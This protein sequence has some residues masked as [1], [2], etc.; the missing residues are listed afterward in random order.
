[1]TER[2]L[3]CFWLT[4]SGTAGGSER[5]FLERARALVKQA[6]PHGGSL[7]SWGGAHV[8]L[9]FE[10]EAIE[11]GVALVAA[12]LADT[13]EGELPWGVALAQGEFVQEK[14]GHHEIVGSMALAEAEALARIAQP[15]DVLVAES[16]AAFASGEMLTV[17]RRSGIDR[18]KRIRAARL[19]C[20]RPWK[21]EAMAHIAQ[22]RTTALVGRED[23]SA[24][25]WM[26]GTL[27]ILRADPGLGG[28]R[29]LADLRRLVEPGPCLVVTPSGSGLEPL[30]AL[31]RAIARACAVD[32]QPFEPELEPA[33]NRLLAGS[34]V[35]IETAATLIASMLKPLAESAPPGALLLDDAAE[36]DSTTLAACARALE[37][38]DCS[39]AFVIRLDAT[40]NV[41]GELLD[42]SLGTEMELRPLAPADAET[43]AG[44]VT[45]GA[46]EPRARKRWAR[47]GNFTPLGILEAITTSLWTGEL[48]W[49][50]GRAFPRRRA[51]G[52]GAPAP[53]GR[54]VAQRAPGTTPAAQ[55][56]LAVTALLGGEAPLKRVEEVLRV[57]NAPIKA[58]EEAQRLV[59]ARWLVQGEPGW[60]GLPSRT[61]REAILS[62]SLG[63]ATRRVIHL[64]IA[65]VLE[66]EERALGLA[67]AALHASR[68]GD[69]EWGARLALTAARAA[70]SL[71]LEKGATQLIAFA[72][73][74][75]PNCEAEARRQLASQLPPKVVLRNDGGADGESPTINGVRLAGF[76]SVQTDSS[77]LTPDRASALA[78]TG[79]QYAAR[80]TMLE[81]AE[82]G[83]LDVQEVPGVLVPSM[84]GET[85]GDSIAV[86]LVGVRPRLEMLAHD[87]EPPTTVAS[88][89]TDDEL[90][91]S[92][93]ASEHATITAVVSGMATS[94]TMLQG[95][96]NAVGQRLSE[97]AKEA[98][99]GA[100]VR[101]LE[102]W[103]EGL[104]ASGERARFAERMQAMARISRGEVGD[105]LRLLRAAR[106]SLDPSSS[107]AA[108]CQTSLA[109]GF[110]LAVAGRTEEALLEGLDAL[111]RAREERNKTAAR[112]CLAFLAKLFA[113]VERSEDATRMR[114][115]AELGAPIS[116][117][118]E[119]VPKT[120]VPSLSGERV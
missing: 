37:I 78:A 31:R 91:A 43:L 87:S 26:P 98:L 28:S 110:A 8:G 56:I 109:L 19:D 99:L 67:E 46:L 118:V 52:K 84:D 92:G 12:A 6:E 16:L 100:D 61:H 24:L 70:Q 64:A 1:V 13:R 55:C 88:P 74:Q 23:P 34:G 58:E 22:I 38:G 104:L 53:A 86:P 77:V 59:A 21:K 40:S 105:A 82:A 83:E 102:R 51:G 45:A 93:P 89:K 106:S 5:G 96:S 41:P 17:G 44:E 111:A 90:D 116:K 66:R 54:W 29:V 57:A 18:G 14:A 25:L 50:E 80:S 30:G 112:A 60:I 117:K 47:R 39:F 2:I 27:S 42:C 4:E 63:E 73:E 120:T 108:R 11:E 3:I 95:D 115:L 36:V 107:P 85:A 69:G 114:S 101:A 33:F 119:S 75:D 72:R 15:G 7:V 81:L 113:S 68:A 65:H 9:L 76:N 10:P 103:V 48:A 71:G 62:E 49:E 20:K 35:P 97:L 32:P 94:D 79:T